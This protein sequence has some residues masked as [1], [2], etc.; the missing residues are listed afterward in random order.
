MPQ[1]HR[2]PGPTVTGSS[3]GTSQHIL[4]AHFGGKEHLFRKAVEH[5]IEIHFHSLEACPRG[6]ESESQ[7]ATI[8]EATVT[9]GVARDGNSRKHFSDSRTRRIFSIQLAAYAVRACLAYGFWLGQRFATTRKALWRL[10][11]DSPSESRRRAGT[12]GGAILTVCRTA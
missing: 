7:A 5:N 10:L 12:T 1:A 6:A 11:R 9:A 8:A 2:C 3:V 4:Y